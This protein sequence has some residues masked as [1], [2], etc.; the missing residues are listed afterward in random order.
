MEEDSLTNF[1]G[2]E[3]RGR[4]DERTDEELY[5]FCCDR[6]LQRAVQGILNVELKPFVLQPVGRHL[7][8]PKHT[9]DAAASQVASEEGMRQEAEC[10]CAR[11]SGPIAFQPERHNGGIISFSSFF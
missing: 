5:R 10:L 6:V 4:N 8:G 11:K 9:I 1:R 2:I 3:E 7:D